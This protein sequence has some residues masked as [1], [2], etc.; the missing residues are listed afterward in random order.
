MK[1]KIIALVLAAA[2]VLSAG[3]ALGQ[4]EE[5][6]KQEPQ[7]GRRV[8]PVE[9]RARPDLPP[10]ERGR[11]VGPEDRPRD[12]MRR[13]P[14]MEEGRNPEEMFRQQMQQRRQEQTESLDELKKILEM[15][16]E[17]NAPKTAAML[18]KLIAKREQAL[19]DRDKRM[20]EMRKRR[21]EMM[22]RRDDRPQ[23]RD[24]VRQERNTGERRGRREEAAEQRRGRRQTEENKEQE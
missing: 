5:E 17:E 2:V 12:G 14:D 24:R 20:E 10:A 16:K 19:A 23:E 13:R 3:L 15:A 1:G 9:D 21:E 4:D 6:K 8:G 7:R 11:R 22:Q 18:E